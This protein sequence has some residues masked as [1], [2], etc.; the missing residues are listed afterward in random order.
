MYLVHDSVA[1]Y[2]MAS[3]YGDFEFACQWKVKGHI[4]CTA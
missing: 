2:R 1:N 3:G 4:G